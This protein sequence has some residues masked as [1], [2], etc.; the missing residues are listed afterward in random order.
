MIKTE[1]PL[2]LAVAVVLILG[3]VFL[4]QSGK[5]ASSAAAP[6]VSAT[7]S[8]VSASVS[9]SKD[10]FAAAPELQGIA[11]YLNAPEG[12]RL[13][14]VKGKVVLVDFWTYSCINCIRT[15]PYL[16]SWDAKYKDQGLVIVGVH[17][18]EFD[19]EKK[20]DNVGSAVREHGIG[21]PVVLDNDYATWRAYQNQYWPHKYLVD[22]EGF[23]RYDHIGEGAYDEREKQIV[24]L[25]QERNASI[26][27]NQSFP[28]VAAE[29]PGDVRTPEIYFGH[30]FIRQPLGNEQQ[31]LAEVPIN[32]TF[33]ASGVFEPNLAYL[34]GTW[35]LY[36]DYAELVSETG[37]VALTFYAQKANIVAGAPKPQAVSVQLDDQAHQ[38]LSVQAHQLYRVASADDAALHTLVFNASKG[39]QLYTFTFG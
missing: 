30:Q 3:A 27:M 17:T 16:T 2:L 35:V 9:A 12:F 29:R 36:K 1:H 28:T 6:S 15:L 18:P 38:A 19:F 33:P 37:H 20:I 5:A 13:S 31:L 24:K 11:G 32:F 39:F 10:G 4:L 21:Y 26:R 7:A 25:L 23:I 14:D 34:D 22:A 8:G